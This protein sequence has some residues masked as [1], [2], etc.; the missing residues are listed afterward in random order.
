M[1]T[2]VR[3]NFPELPVINGDLILETFSHKSLT[4]GYDPEKS[5]DNE[6]L[7]ILGE[8]VMQ[9]IVTNY[10]YNKR[11]IISAEDMSVCLDSVNYGR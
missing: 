2:A 7:A 11:P 6:R 1:S 10:L 8:S 5:F 9:T 4:M 3:T